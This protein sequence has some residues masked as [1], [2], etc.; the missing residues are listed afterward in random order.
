M[1][2]NCKIVND[3][4]KTL[5]SQATPG[6]KDAFITPIRKY[7]ASEHTQVEIYFFLLPINKFFFSRPN[8]LIQGDRVS[9]WWQIIWWLENSD[10]NLFW[11]HI[12]SH[13][14]DSW[15]RQIFIFQNISEKIEPK[16]G[17]YKILFL[18]MYIVPQIDNLSQR[19]STDYCF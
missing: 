8:M 3:T 6:S 2:Q 18:S 12:W 14:P 11:G 7:N 4:S 19:L 13:R 17:K 9:N 5:I 15:K 1:F 10:N 16:V